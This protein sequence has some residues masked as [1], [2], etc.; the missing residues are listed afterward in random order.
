MTMPDVQ[1]LERAVL[2]TIVRLHAADPEGSWSAYHPEVTAAA[3]DDIG[4]ASQVCRK[5][6]S[7]KLLAGDGRGMHAFYWPTDEG[8]ARARRDADREGASA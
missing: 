7:R 3:A 8:I 1:A 4:W 6:R 2:A 5:L